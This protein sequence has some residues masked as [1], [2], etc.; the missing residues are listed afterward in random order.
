MNA[1]R[2]LFEIISHIGRVTSLQNWLAKKSCHGQTLINACSI[3]DY[4]SNFEVH[5][6]IDFRLVGSRQKELVLSGRLAH[7]HINTPKIRISLGKHLE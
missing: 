3:S 1:K 5:L 2:K 4:P 6:I 7:F